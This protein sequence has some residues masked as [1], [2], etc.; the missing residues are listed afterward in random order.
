MGFKTQFLKKIKKKG[1]AKAGYGPHLPK[2]PSPRSLFTLLGVANHPKGT[3]LVHFRRKNAFA[4]PRTQLR[5]QF[6]RQIRRQNTFST[7]FSKKDKKKGGFRPPK[8]FYANSFVGYASARRV[9]AFRIR[10][11]MISSLVL[12]CSDGILWCFRPYSRA[13]AL[14]EMSKST[15]SSN[16]SSNLFILGSKMGT[17]GQFSENLAFFTRFRG[18]FSLPCLF[19]WH[20]GRF[21][22]V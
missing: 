12:R 8:L 10:L 7:P 9:L 14:S 6:L 2:T 20:T 17:A 11:F 16:V 19:P 21:C 3:L 15:N 13:F 1:Q 5:L 22:P 4:D 18:R